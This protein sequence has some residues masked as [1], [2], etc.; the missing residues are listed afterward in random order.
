[1]C[2][3]EA[4]EGKEKDP[5]G[6]DGIPLT[7]RASVLNKELTDM[8]SESQGGEM[9]GDVKTRAT[10]VQNHIALPLPYLNHHFMR[11]R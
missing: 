10:F 4:R 8:A 7:L 1:M 6:G 5:G 9:G 3:A 2:S 11:I